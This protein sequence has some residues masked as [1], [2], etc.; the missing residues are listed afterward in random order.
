[1]PRAALAACHMRQMG[2]PWELCLGSDSKSR[3]KN[4]AARGNRAN[5]GLARIVHRTAIGRVWRRWGASKAYQ[6]TVGTS[7]NRLIA[8]FCTV[9]MAAA[10]RT[11][12][13]AMFL[14]GK[15]RATIGSGQTSMPHVDCPNLSVFAR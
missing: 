3:N 7:V 15:V 5:P 6:N 8:G 13:P 9:R 11:E 2:A 14:T 12:T 1:M 4:I 10:G